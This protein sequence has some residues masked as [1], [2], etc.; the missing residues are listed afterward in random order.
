MGRI[1]LGQIM[2]SLAIR[3]PE[4]QRKDRSTSP[5]A[6]RGYGVCMYRGIEVRLDAS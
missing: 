1:Q 2:Q 6:E 5:L 3:T 4:S